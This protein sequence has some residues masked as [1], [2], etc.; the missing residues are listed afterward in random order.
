MTHAKLQLAP[1]D[2][3]ISAVSKMKRATGNT[4]ASLFPFT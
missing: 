2:P 1:S 4:F 3:L